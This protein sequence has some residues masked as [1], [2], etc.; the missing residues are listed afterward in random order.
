LAKQFF[1]FFESLPKI[2]LADTSLAAKN[3]NN[4]TSFVEYGKTKK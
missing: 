1:Y 4:K 3:K 2:Y